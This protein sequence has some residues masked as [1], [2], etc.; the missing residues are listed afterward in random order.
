M[1]ALALTP[2]TR[3]SRHDNITNGMGKAFSKSRFPPPTKSNRMSYSKQA[4]APSTTSAPLIPDK[5]MP[6]LYVSDIYT[7]RAVLSPNYPSLN[8]PEIKYVLSVIDNPARQPKVTPGDESKF[9]LKLIRLRD[10]STEDLLEVLEEAC[11]FIRDSLKRNDGGVLVHCAKGVSRSASVVIGFVMEDMDLEYDTALRYVRQGRS[12]VKPN[13]GFEG[14][15][16]L[17]RRLEYSIYEAGGTTH[18]E[19]YVIW[20]A[21]NEEA[22]KNL[23]LKNTHPH[24]EKCKRD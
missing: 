6:G 22:I 18:K 24:A 13:V 8:R 12:K 1:L 9:V 17:W 5:I 7:A 3:R 19:E 10:S 2:T 4:S 14:Q 15:L 16:Q 11:D 23:T 20:K 21:N